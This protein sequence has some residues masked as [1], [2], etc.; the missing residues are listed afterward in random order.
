[1]TNTPPKTNTAYYITRSA[2]VVIDLLAEILAE[3]RELR[4]DMK[5]GH[6]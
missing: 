6:S 2:Q 5:N 1:M 4:K 3:L